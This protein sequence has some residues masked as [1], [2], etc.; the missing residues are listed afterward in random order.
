MVETHPPLREVLLERVY[1][2]PVYLEDADKRRIL[3]ETGNPILDEMG[4]RI[5]DDG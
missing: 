4:A 3:D 5:F 2:V 1:L